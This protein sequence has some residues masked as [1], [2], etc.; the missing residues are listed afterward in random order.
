MGGMASPQRTVAESTAGTAYSPL[1]ALSSPRASEERLLP[2][3]CCLFRA[4]ATRAAFLL[5]TKYYE[6]NELLAW[7]ALQLIDQYG[8]ATV[9]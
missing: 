7:C 6:K 5:Y 4:Q 9:S 8:Y 3:H 1:L 2:S